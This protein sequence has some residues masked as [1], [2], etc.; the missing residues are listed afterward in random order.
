[1]ADE[2]EL[3][4]HLGSLDAEALLEAEEALQGHPTLE[5]VSMPA[6]YVQMRLG[7]RVICRVGLSLS[8]HKDG[9]GRVDPSLCTVLSLAP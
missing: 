9:L 1:M 2:L 5:G 4:A 6:G 3:E 8:L 7:G